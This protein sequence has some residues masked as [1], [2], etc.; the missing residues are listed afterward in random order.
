MLE[1]GETILLVQDTASLN[2]STHKKTEG[3]GYISGKTLGVNIRTC[4]AVTAGGMVLGA[5]DQSSYNREEAK[6]ER[7]THESKKVRPLEEKERYR[8]MKTLGESPCG[9]SEGVQ[10]VSVCGREGDMAD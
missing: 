8:R 4:L 5:A 10:T 7:R 6:D 2:C 1:A 3:I 9:I